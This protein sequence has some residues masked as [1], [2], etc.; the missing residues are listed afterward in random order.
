MARGIHRIFYDD[1]CALCIRWMRRLHR[2]DWWGRFRLV[3]RSGPE[4]QASGL[5]PEAL[6]DAIHCVSADGR[7]LRGA[8]CLRFVG[9]RLPL[10]APLAWLLWLPGVLPL[11]ER[12]Y[13]ELSRRRMRWGQAPC[14]TP[15]CGLSPTGGPPDSGKARG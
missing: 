5:S 7:V 15:G 4:A 8:A 2:L 12:A 1:Q 10:L 3:P 13:T 14:P 6:A 9:L 11:T